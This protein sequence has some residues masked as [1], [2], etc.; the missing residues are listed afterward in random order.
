MARDHRRGD[1][2]HRNVFSLNTE[3]FMSKALTDLMPNEV[4]LSSY[5]LMVATFSLY[6]SLTDKKEEGWRET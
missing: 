5:F 4:S 2:E 1:V 6:H 3:E